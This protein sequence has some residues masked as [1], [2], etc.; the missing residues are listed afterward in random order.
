[1]NTHQYSGT[2]VMLFTIV[3]LL[4]ALSSAQAQ[5][6]VMPESGQSPATIQPATGTPAASA[7]TPVSGTAAGAKQT[8]P[9]GEVRI[10]SG[11]L[12]EVSVF[13][14][15]EFQKVEARV[16][17]QGEISLPMLGPVHVAGVNAEQAEK[18]VA[19]QLS[20]RQLFNEPHVTIFVKEYATQGVSVLGE[21]LKPGV[22]PVLGERQLFDA[23]SLAGGLT[24]KAGSVVSVTHR[25]ENAQSIQVAISNDPEKSAASNVKVYPGDTIFVPRAGIVY[26]IGDV[27]T[28]GGFVIDNSSRMTVLKAVALAQGANSTASLN[29]AKLVRKTPT[30][31]EEK[32]LELKKILTGKSPDVAMQ[33]DDIVFVPN[34]APKS[35]TKR[36]LE[37][38]LQT[39]TGV[40]IYHPY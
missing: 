35:A 7:V 30:G 16:S 28:P 25:T 24:P 29:S 33:A 31:Q 23:I 40:A 18:L 19:D 37:A 20:K 34:S 10:G 8:Q 4:I 26:V 39:A 1:M 6:R 3:V 22:Y 14:A 5:T 27:K 13:G 9:S 36:G 17:S 11:D 2:Q 32:P 15:P 12:L 21:V 38:I